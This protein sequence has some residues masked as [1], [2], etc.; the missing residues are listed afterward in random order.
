[1]HLRPSTKTETLNR[2]RIQMQFLY[3]LQGQ[4]GSQNGSQEYPFLKRYS[5][6]DMNFPLL[7]NISTYPMSCTHKTGILPRTS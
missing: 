3:Q 2:T 5:R 7:E 4:Q 1:M 6:E